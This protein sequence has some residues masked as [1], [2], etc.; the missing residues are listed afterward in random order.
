MRTNRE[1]VE[2]L[3]E[4][5]DKKGLS[6]SEL[7]RRV[8]MAKSALSRYFNFTR[9][10]PLNRADDFSKALGITTEY[11]LGV[12]ESKSKENTTKQILDNVFAK[13]NDTRQ[14]KVVAY[15]KSELD[16][17]NKDSKVQEIAEYI[18]SKKYDFYDDAVSAGTGQYVGTSQKEHISLP[19]DIECDYV[20]PVYGDSMEPEYHDGDYIFIESTVNVSDGEIGVFEFDGQTYVKKLILEYDHAYL[21]SLNDKYE[22]MKVT[23]ESDFRVLGRVVGRY[24]EN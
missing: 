10:F 3:A 2:I 11:L 22:D 24:A 14:E 15:A 9:E 17:Q 8:D 7:A 12:N 13:L 21:H 6:I 1:I 18:V 19:V 4:E 5:R 20:V 16:E 23:A